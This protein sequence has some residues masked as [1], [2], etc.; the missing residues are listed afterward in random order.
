MEQS[1]REILEKMQV[2]I[3]STM[4]RFV[5][6]EAFY[7]RMLGKFEKDGTFEALKAHVAQEDYGEAFKDAHTLK[8]L[9]ANLGLGIMERDIVDLTEMLRNEPFDRDQIQRLYERV[10]V[11]YQ[12]CVESIRSLQ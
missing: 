4:Q 7:L 1:T 6:N 9:S 5:D 12:M 3:P 11:E 2:D 10:A 8:G